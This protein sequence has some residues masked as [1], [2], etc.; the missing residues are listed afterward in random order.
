[1]LSFCFFRGASC[2][3]SRR[4]LFLGVILHVS[5]SWF[6]RSHYWCLDLPSYPFHGVSFWFIENSWKTNH[7]YLRPPFQRLLGHLLRQSFEFWNH[8][9]L[10]GAFRMSRIERN[11]IQ[12]QTRPKE[13]EKP[14]FVGCVLGFHCDILVIEAYFTSIFLENPKVFGQEKVGDFCWSSFR[15]FW[16]QPKKHP[17][18]K[19]NELIGS[20]IP[21]KF[22]PWSWTASSEQGDSWKIQTILPLSS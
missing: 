6:F 19:R 2:C 14:G 5:W 21:S 13:Q 1:M 20:V 7:S 8:G 10:L 12:S 4:S 16:N 11:R 15:G 22:H 9:L 17:Q 18:S 3:D